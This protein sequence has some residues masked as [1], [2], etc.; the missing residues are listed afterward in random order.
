MNT[1]VILNG[2]LWSKDR[3]DFSKIE[4]IKGGLEKY[5]ISL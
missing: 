3:I 4:S 1:N 2:E 5:G